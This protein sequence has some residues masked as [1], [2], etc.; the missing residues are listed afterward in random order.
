ML[1]KTL[2]VATL[3]LATAA[4]AQEDKFPSRTVRI[5][6]PF[7]AG[8]LTDTLARMYAEELS[9][10]FNQ[11]V[12]VENKP[13]SG[14]IPATQAMLGAA[15]GYT[16]QMVSSG[17]AVNPTLFSK[18]PYDTLKDTVGVALVASSPT[19]AV[20][21]PA[22]GIKTL[23][24]FIAAS[25]K[26]SGGLNYGSAGIGSSTHLVAE[27]LRDEAKIDMVHVPYKGVQEAVTEV[28]A[29][30]I[31]IAFPPIA[32]ALP[33]MKAGRI[34]AI[35]QTGPQ[36][37]ALIPDIPTVQEQGIKGF[38][39]SIWYAL[40]APAKAPHAALERMAKEI[41]EISALPAVKEKMQ[42]QGLVQNLLTLG[43]FDKYIKSE[44]EKQGRLV[45]ASGA[46]A[47]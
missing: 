23:A 10:R 6:V 5:I 16:Y 14:G 2:L 37:S 41:R 7:S 15:D 11:P 13:G 26:K 20:V 40:I 18:L 47:D 1:K 27:Y 8:A 42:Q 45:K 17:H 9:K 12:V 24:E 39:Y 33:Q 44:V 35:A 29:G 30:R 19:V 38:D 21:N 22:S 31:D 25:K 3:L 46:K 32:L 36:R 34:V 28:L 4:H 43:D